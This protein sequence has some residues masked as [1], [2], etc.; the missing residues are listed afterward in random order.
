MAACGIA[1]V[2]RAPSLA[3]HVRCTSKEREHA[4]PRKMAAGAVLSSSA[5]LLRTRSREGK[6]KQFS[7]RG[8][9]GKKQKHTKIIHTQC[10]RK[11]ARRRLGD[12]VDGKMPFRAPALFDL[13]IRAWSAKSTRLLL[14]LPDPRIGE[15][16]GVDGAT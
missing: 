7:R 4:R 10:L 5:Y 3:G 11:A 13:E 1:S 15:V 6:Q 14:P 16:L 8:A 2:V 9:G 12:A